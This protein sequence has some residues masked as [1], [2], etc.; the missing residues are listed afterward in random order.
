MKCLAQNDSFYST[1]APN[2]F[3][4][5]DNPSAH[6]TF[7]ELKSRIFP[8]RVAHHAGIEKKLGKNAGW[9]VATSLQFKQRQRA[10]SSSD[11]IDGAFATS[12]NCIAPSHRFPEESDWQL[13]IAFPALEL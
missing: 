9:N 13:P 12:E 4:F 8:H 5:Y 3:C 2:V 11:E 10:S 1:T 7:L 6:W